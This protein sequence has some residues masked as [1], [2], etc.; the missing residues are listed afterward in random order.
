MPAEA[1]ALQIQP[2]ESIALAPMTLE[3]TPCWDDLRKPLV[4]LLLKFYNGEDQG[5]EFV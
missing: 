5:H 1:A 3:M 4:D 2:D